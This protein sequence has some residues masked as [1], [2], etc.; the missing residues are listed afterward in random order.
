MHT[1]AGVVSA[2]L[3]FLL[4]Q[5]SISLAQNSVTIRADNPPIWG[6]DV[7]LMQE[8]RIGVLDG[9]PE[10]VFGWIVDMALGPDGSIFVVE[11]QGAVVRKYSPD[12]EYLH[13]IGR[14]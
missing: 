8:V 4:S 11:G 5:P 13:D 9:E 10:Y 7:E 14:E 6:N 1:R 3:A 2:F 12:G